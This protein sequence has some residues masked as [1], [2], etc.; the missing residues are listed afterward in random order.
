MK[1]ITVIGARPQFVKAAV[2]SLALKAQGHQEVLVHTG[3][4]YD[5]RMSDVFFEEL[6][7]PTPQYHLGIGGLM[8][9]AMTGR[10]LEEIELVLLQEKP[11]YVLVYGDT[12]STLA[13]ALAAAK[14]HI[15]IAHVEAGMRSFNRQMPE[16]INRVLVDHLSQLFFVTSQ[17]PV[18]L[19]AQEGIFTGVHCVGDVMYDAVLA[20]S[21]RASE[22]HLFE[23]WEL[24]SKQYGLVTLHRAENTDHPATLAVWLTQF[25]LLSQQLKLIFV[26]HPRTAQVIQKIQ[27][28]W[29]PENIDCIEPQGYLDM[30][31]L[32]KHAALIITDS[33]GIQKEAL[34]LSTPCLTLRKETEWSETVESGWNHLLGDQPEQLVVQAGLMI[35]KFTGQKAPLL[36]G[37]GNASEKIAHILSQ[38]KVSI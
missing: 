9:G 31:L 38:K 17:N 26:I 23:K 5:A 16:E 21:A 8:H 28:D 19:L 25:E 18:E 3:Q 6:G 37:D 1:I 13:G 15:P 24:Q 10:M 33:G 34:Y 36:Y 27:P 22:S 30:L 14:L 32:Q 7:L 35:Q 2:V 11:D 20:F 12:N 29:N 4:H